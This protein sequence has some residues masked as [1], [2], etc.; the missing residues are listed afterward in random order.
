[1]TPECITDE[2][3]RLCNVGK[4]QTRHLYCLSVPVFPNRKFPFPYCITVG[5]TGWQYEII[6]KILNPQGC[7]S[8]CLPGDLTNQD[9]LVE[10]YVHRE[11]RLA[12]GL[13]ATTKRK[14]RTTS[15]FL[16]YCAVAWTKI[17][18][19]STPPTGLLNS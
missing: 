5:L 10:H 12:I 6:E 2:T 11:H 18:E 15:A 3:A 8:V 17:T 14:W 13:L 16:P 19:V 4:T 7:P 9:S 1:M